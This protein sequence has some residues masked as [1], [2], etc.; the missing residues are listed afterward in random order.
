MGSLVIM[1]FGFM[2]YGFIGIHGLKFS[3]AIVETA[4]SH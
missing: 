4:V 3:G 2:A 1:G